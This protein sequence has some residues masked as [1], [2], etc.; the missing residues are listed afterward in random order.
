LSGSI[1]S[2]QG[3]AE[4]QRASCGSPFVF[5]PGGGGGGPGSPGPG[6]NRRGTGGAGRGL[7]RGASRSPQDGRGAT[8]SGSPLASVAPGQKRLGRGR[9]HAQ[10]RHPFKIACRER[11]QRPRPRPRRAEKR[12][13]ALAR[14]RDQVG[15]G[16]RQAS[17]GRSGGRRRE[18]TGGVTPRGGAGAIYGAAPARHI[19]AARRPQKQG[20]R[21]QRHPLGNQ[22][23]C[24]RRGRGRGPARAR[25][26]TS[27]PPRRDPPRA[28]EHPRP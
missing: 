18:G 2:T 7:S 4:W 8:R 26:G 22:E 9:S 6:G 17:G 12:R 13:G 19:G 11:S 1:E 16:G 21:R 25:G 27:Y 10:T 28:R 24:Q 15:G 23:P 14:D 20:Q 5:L 3:G